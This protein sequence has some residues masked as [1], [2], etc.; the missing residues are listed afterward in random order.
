MSERHEH[1]ETGST[2]DPV[3]GM[4]VDPETTAHHYHHGG[5][6]YHFCSAGCRGEFEA[7]PDDYLTGRPPAAPAP[8]G[9][10]Y[11]CPMHPEIVRDGPG[12]CPL[13]GMAL[14]PM[15]VPLD[16]GPSP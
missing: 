2:T 14:E 10:Q 11:T 13:C 9:T 8:L 1:A 4:T 6:D 15:G 7:A 16:E 5:L 12:T 3:C